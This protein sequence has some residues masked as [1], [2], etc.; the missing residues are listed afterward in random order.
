MKKTFKTFDEEYEPEDRISSEINNF[1]K[2]Q[3]LDTINNE[4]AITVEITKI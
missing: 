4:Y 3:K 2:D 1:I